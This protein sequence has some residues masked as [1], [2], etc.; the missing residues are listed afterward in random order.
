MKI[1]IVVGH[2]E[3]S[4]GA[5]RVSDGVTEFE[6]NSELAELIRRIDPENVKVFFRRPLG[7]G[8]Y[9]RQ[10]DTVYAE[11]DAWGADVSVELHF[12]S[13]SGSTAN[14][15]ETLSSGSRGSVRAA[16]S[17]QSEMLNALGL[18]NRGIKYP[19]RNHRGGRSL[20]AGRAPAVLVEPFFGSSLRDCKS[21][22]GKICDLAQAIYRGAKFF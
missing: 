17:I 4:R 15:T 12:N 11:V 7:R 1:A 3:M 18:K 21:V 8:S 13:L 6:F 9:A 10:I 22:D 19:G 20:F 2:N 16:Q 14:G 5:I